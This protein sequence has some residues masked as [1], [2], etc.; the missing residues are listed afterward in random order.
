MST[1]SDTTA[2]ADL[3]DRLLGELRLDSSVRQPAREKDLAGATRATLIAVTAHV[4]VMVGLA[5]LSVPQG[6]KDAGIIETLGIEIVDDVAPTPVG[7]SALPESGRDTRAAP[8]ADDLPDQ[9]VAGERDASPAMPVADKSEAPLED[10]PKAEQTAETEATPRPAFD[11]FIALARQAAEP[12]STPSPVAVPGNAGVVTTRLP[13]IERGG[14]AVDAGAYELKVMEALRNRP[15]R[16][17]P[18]R[19][20]RVVV[21]FSIA[22][23]GTVSGVYVKRSSGAVDLD[24]AALV[25]IRDARFPPPPPTMSPRH[26]YEIPYT[27]R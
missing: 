10:A 12:A 22:R 9:T 19:R 3:A 26:E 11:A 16:P 23:D 14:G 5:R 4:A 6:F 24:Q 7:E 21:A 2:P 1:E 13:E 25:A 27:F 8:I 17:P 20:G 15:P 18:D